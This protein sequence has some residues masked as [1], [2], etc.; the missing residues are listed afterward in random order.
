MRQVP[1]RIAHRLIT[2]TLVQAF[3][4]QFGAGH[5]LFIIELSQVLQAL[6]QMLGITQREQDAHAFDHFLGPPTGRRQQRHACGHGLKQ[7]HTERLVVGGQHEHV[8]RL[9]IT[10]TIRH[11]AEKTHRLA[12][13]QLSRQRLEL[14]LQAGDAFAVAADGDDDL[15]EEAFIVLRE[16]LKRTRKVGLGQLAMR[17]R[18]YVVSLKPCGRG[19]VLEPFAQTLI[20]GAV[21]SGYAPEAVKSGW[22]PKIAAGESLVVLAYQER[23]ARYHFDKCE[24]KATQ[25]QGGWALTAINSAVN[26]WARVAPRTHGAQA[27]RGKASPN[28]PRCAQPWRSAAG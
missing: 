26:D 15:A 9:E 22:L 14:R 16:A 7:H 27:A 6:C 24:A 11:L 20:A 28:P 17:G 13:A 3:K 8:E 10:T 5:T 21:L 23:A 2:E 18:E 12:D 1:E 19:M 25:V 4:H